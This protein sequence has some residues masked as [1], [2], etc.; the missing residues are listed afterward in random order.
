M[1]DTKDTIVMLFHNRAAA[2]K[3]CSDLKDR[4]FSADACQIISPD[5]LPQYGRGEHAV[6]ERPAT[7]GL[8]DRLGSFFGLTDTESSKYHS[9]AD[10]LEA[11]GMSRNNADYYEREVRSGSTML[12]VKGGDRADEIRAL[13]E[14]GTGPRGDVGVESVPT[15]TDVESA[16]T[17]ADVDYRTRARSFQDKEHI[18]LREEVAD[19]ERHQAKAGEAQ[20]SKHIVTEHEMIDVPKRRE[21]LVVERHP[22]E[23][24]P[25]ASGDL[26]EESFTVPLMEEDI[27]IG[28]H[29]VVYEEVDIGKREVT[30]IE[31][32]DVELRREELEIRRPGE[33]DLS[34]EEIRRRRLDERER[35][36]A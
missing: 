18:E 15:R 31:R 13:A 35:P 16:P 12:M 8:R 11:K 36:A 4:N 17:R 5:D 14:Q 29:S 21:E 23:G 34:D 2:D 32:E 3:F 22:V 6:I 26:E 9:L 1:Y 28:K 10:L 20:V 27:T 33:E 19:I 30:S 25:S 24:R 7:G